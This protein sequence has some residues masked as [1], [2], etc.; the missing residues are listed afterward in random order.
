MPLSFYTLSPVE[1]SECIQLDIMDFIGALDFTPIPANVGRLGR[2]A[3]YLTG[4][5]LN[6]VWAEFS[7]LS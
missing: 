4:E 5:N 2:G 1:E 6:V 7:T 3:Q